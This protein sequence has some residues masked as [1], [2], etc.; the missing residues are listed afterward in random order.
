MGDNSAGAF[1]CGG[2]YHSLANEIERL[3]LRKIL[4]G[5]RS[6]M[7]DGQQRRALFRKEAERITKQ[8]VKALE[9]P[10]LDRIDQGR[11]C[12]RLL[13][14]VG[15][16]LADHYRYGTKP[17]EQIVEGIAHGLDQIRSAGTP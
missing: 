16:L 5:G 8:I 2:R 10:R 7:D 17:A 11:D 9:R 13:G 15:Y 12:Y 4:E 6:T 1:H 14:M 3:H